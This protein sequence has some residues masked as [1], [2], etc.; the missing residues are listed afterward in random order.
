MA[1]KATTLE[2]AATDFEQH[3]KT[4]DTFLSLTILGIIHVVSIVMIIAIFGL[5]GALWLGSIALALTL[6]TLMMGLFMRG[7]WKPAIFSFAVTLLFFL[8]AV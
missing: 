1:E 8:I 7:N 4:Y 3:E 5:A 6:T 2:G